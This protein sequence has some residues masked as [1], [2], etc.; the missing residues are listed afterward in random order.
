MIVD[1]VPDNQRQRGSARL[2]GH[3]HAEQLHGDEQ[4]HLEILTGPVNAKGIGEC[5]G[6][7]EHPR[8]E[9]VEG[10]Q[11]WGVG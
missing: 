5:G 7:A 1:S 3:E 4:P 8:T 2:S 9:A 6:P 11:S 10:E